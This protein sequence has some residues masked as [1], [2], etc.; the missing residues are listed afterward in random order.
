MDESIEPVIKTY[1]GEGG[2][3]LTNRL[4]GRRP[5]LGEQ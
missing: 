2:I 4:Q 1:C 3:P 5:G